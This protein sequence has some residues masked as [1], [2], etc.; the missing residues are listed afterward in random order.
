MARRAVLGWGVLCV[1]GVQQRA[2][3]EV[4]VRGPLVGVELVPLQA[5]KP[6]GAASTSS[7]QGP[8]APRGWQAGTALCAHLPLDPEHPPLALAPQLLQGWSAECTRRPH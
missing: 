5:R 4:V 2:L 3:F 7:R 1:P 6:L 8:A